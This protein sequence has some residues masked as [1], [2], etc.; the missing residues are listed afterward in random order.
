MI[1]FD[2]RCQGGHVFEGWFADAAAFAAQRAQA[3]VACPYCNSSLVE[4]VLSAPRLNAKSNQRIDAP[5]T[6]AV[7]ESQDAKAL[8]AALLAVQAK[9][10][11]T[12][13][14]VGANFASEARAIAEGDAAAR[15]IYGVASLDEVRALADDG[16]PVAPLPLPPRRNWNS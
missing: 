5:A 3:L 6:V 9:V 16:I 13:E 12:F 1:V 7:G 4:R 15:G 10:E 11:A 8:M 2:L 14:D